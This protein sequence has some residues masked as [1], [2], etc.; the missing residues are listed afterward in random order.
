[1]DFI[2]NKK[3]GDKKRNPQRVEENI[4]ITFWCHSLKIASPI[5]GHLRMQSSFVNFVIACA[6]RPL[7]LKANS[8]KL[9]LL[10]LF[11]QIWTSSGV[12]CSLS[13]STR[14]LRA[15]VRCSSESSFVSSAANFLISSER[16]IEVPVFEFVVLVVFGASVLVGSFFLFDPNF[17][18]ESN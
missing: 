3:I 18:K 4:P 10:M 9:P 15:F 8:A 17:Q 12:Q 7:N 2:Q 5:S 1:M 6:L 13:F 16:W 11:N 14:Y